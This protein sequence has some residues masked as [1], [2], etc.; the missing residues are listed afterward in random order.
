MAQTELFAKRE[1]AGLRV[2][3]LL[4]AAHPSL[5]RRALVL[6]F[7]A[8]GV[9]INGRRASKGDRIAAGDVVAFDPS[10][11]EVVATPAQHDP[12]RL[13]LVNDEVVVFDK[14][15]GV[16]SMAVPGRLADTAA[17]QLVAL[18]PELEHVG[19][20]PREPGLVHRLDTYTSGLLLAAR[21]PAAFDLLRAAMRAGRIEKRYLAVTHGTAP[22][23]GRVDATLEPDPRNPRRVR[24]LDRPGPRVTLFRRLEVRGGESLLEVTLARGYRHQIRAHLAAIGLPLVGDVLYGGPGAGLAPRHALHAS[25]LECRDEAVRFRAEA[26]LPEDLASYWAR[27]AANDDTRAP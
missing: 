15:A 26:P 11:A 7:Q 27:A 20:G 17:G 13:V 19:Y 16:P 24:A 1:H 25:F 4:S 10:A 14:P 6:L 8:G 9:T 21:T 3:R 23:E 5:S 18:F 12:S 22:A 2:D